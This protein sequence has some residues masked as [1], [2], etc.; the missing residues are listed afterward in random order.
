MPG[1]VRGSL[2]HTET[3]LKAFITWAS[4]GT[5]AAANTTIIAAIVIVKRRPVRIAQDSFPSL[6]T[7]APPDENRKGRSCKALTTTSSIAVLIPIALMSNY[8]GI[9]RLGS[10]RLGQS[11]IHR[12]SV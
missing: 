11:A 7:R 2:A 6:F 9:A 1:P 8:T 5:F 12:R 10:Y 4:A 3:R